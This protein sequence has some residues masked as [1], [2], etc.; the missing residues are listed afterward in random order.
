MI[1]Q[2]N[3]EQ[4]ASDTQVQHT[5]GPW[6]AGKPS[7]VVG[8]PVVATPHWRVICNMNYVQHSMIDPSVPGDRAFNTESA[9]NARLIAAAPEL[10][11]CA[12]ILAALEDEYN[13]RTFP[14]KEQCAQARAAIAKATAP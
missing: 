3:P 14:T 9:A 12:R 8:W 11:D 1:D 13:G 10:L 7:S 2:N 6:L 5:P 4:A